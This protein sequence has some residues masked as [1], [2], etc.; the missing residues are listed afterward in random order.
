MKID[1]EG[2]ELKVL[3]GAHRVIDSNPAIKILMEWSVPQLREQNTNPMDILD[4]F[5]S[6]GFTPSVLDWRDGS[7]QSV[8][9]DYITQKGYICSVL[10]ERNQ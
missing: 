8:D 1:V 9:Y 3:N 5:K 6:K 10:F 7:K 2:A 4:F